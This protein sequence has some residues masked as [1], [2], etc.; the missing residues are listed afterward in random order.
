MDSCECLGNTCI[1]LLFDIVGP[2][3]VLRFVN[4][5]TIGVLLASKF[6]MMSQPE[7]KR[8]MHMDHQP[9]FRTRYWVSGDVPFVGFGHY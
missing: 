7:I 5:Q 6:L 8:F 3:N 9:T 1:D 4:T 2:T